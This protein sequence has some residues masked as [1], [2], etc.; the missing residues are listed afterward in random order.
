[1]TKSGALGVQ[2]GLTLKQSKRWSSC[3]GEKSHA[4][5]ARRSWTFLTMASCF[6]A[7]RHGRWQCSQSVRRVREDC[8]LKWFSNPGLRKETVCCSCGIL[9]KEFQVKNISFCHQWMTEFSNCQ[10]STSLKLSFDT[11]PYFY[12]NCLVWFLCC[13][14]NVVDEKLDF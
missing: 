14:R 10:L 3:S 12:I 13:S 1:M 2:T 8:L 9:L 7:C 5:L 6:P 4:S 11:V